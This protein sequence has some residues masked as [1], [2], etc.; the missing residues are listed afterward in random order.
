MGHLRGDA[1]QGRGRGPLSDPSAALRPALAEWLRDDTDVI[2]AFGANPVRVL[3]K[4]PPTNQTPPYAF[5]PPFQVF[6]DSAECLDAV[7][8]DVQ[9]EA[10]SLTT[11][12]GYAEVEALCA[13]LNT[14]MKRTEDTGDSPAF[15]VSGWRVV[16]AQYISTT[17]LAD[18]SKKTAGSAVTYRLAIDPV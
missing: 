14:A 16:S 17:P 6:D 7:E 10:W 18:L 2:A 12:P 15:S 9:V 4:V 1:A 11:A 5:I 13:A 8:V 3:S